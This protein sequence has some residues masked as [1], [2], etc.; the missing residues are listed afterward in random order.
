MKIFDE[1]SQRARDRETGKK[2]YLHRKREKIKSQIR[3]KMPFM[4]ALRKE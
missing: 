1:K 3:Q 2:Q 4:K